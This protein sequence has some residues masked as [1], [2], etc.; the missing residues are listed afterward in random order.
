[1]NLFGSIVPFI[2]ADLELDGSMNSTNVTL[3]LGY[4]ELYQDLDV[5]DAY[6]THKLWVS[7]RCQDN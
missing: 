3:A 5:Q 2:L 4:K 7:R 6:P 1:M